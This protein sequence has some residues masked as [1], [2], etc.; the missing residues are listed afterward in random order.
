MNISVD[1]SDTNQQ[2]VVSA[3]AGSR[4]LVVA[5]PGTGKTQVSAQRLA[6]LVGMALLPSEVLVLSFSRSAVR[7]L[8]RRIGSC[9]GD[10]AEAV[11]DLRHLAVRT[12]D[13]WAFRMLRTSGI[14]P[15]VLMRSSYEENIGRL[16]DILEAASPNAVH[17]SLERIRHIVVDECQDIV[18]VRLR[19]VKA[20][21]ALLAPPQAS[22]NGF[23]ILG[24]DAQAIYGFSARAKGHPSTAGDTLMQHVRDR[25][26]GQFEEIVLQKNYRSTPALA[27]AVDALRRLFAVETDVRTRLDKMEEFV[28]SL[29]TVWTESLSPAWLGTVDGGSLAILARTNGEA[30]RIA[31][32]LGGKQ[33]AAPEIPVELHLATRNA[34]VP[35]W[36]GVL[37]GP[38]RNDTISRT[39]FGKIHAHWSA[40]LGGEN[41]LS[42]SLPPEDLAWI[43]LARACGLADDATSFSIQ[44]LR[45]R[46][47]WADA[48]PDDVGV[49]AP[50]V[51]ISTIHHAKG[52]EFDGVVLLQ[53]KMAE[54]EETV[55]VDA[56]EI[57]AEPD[58]DPAEEASVLFVAVTRAAKY[59]G[60]LPHDSIYRP[61]HTR[62]FANGTRQRLMTRGFGWVNI[63]IGIP[64]DIAICSHVDTTMHGSS[65]HVSASQEMLW[66]TSAAL[67]GRKV[68]LCKAF[69][70]KPDGKRHVHYNIHLQNDT[71]PGEFLGRTGPNLTFDLLDLL[72]SKYTLPPSIFNLRI[73]SVISIAGPTEVPATVADP[74]RTS[75]L[76]LGISLT[77]TGDFKP[78]KSKGTKK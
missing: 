10:G 58:A 64:G 60:T 77:G 32:Q 49:A 1:D 47:D 76:W 59:L 40:E 29:P 16:A 28:A 44:A 45:A 70:E 27:N 78:F 73:G 46:L 15:D 63:E 26:A 71:V 37:L 48:F 2:R 75:G 13:S 53:K 9:I 39:L 55:E 69:E 19:L 72:G 14:P 54:Q 17:A 62:R 61:Y 36:V 38:A 66:S 5:G 6:H 11:E 30:L 21:L 8:M 65:E 4:M 24:D 33:S 34:P 23:T 35:A 57:S 12:F 74:F 43:R 3:N 52:M 22:G 67:S 25:Y 50:R 68:V 56:E 42:V 18:G 7:T 51:A 41:S 20:L 31:T